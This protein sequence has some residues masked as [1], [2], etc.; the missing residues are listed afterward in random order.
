MLRAGVVCRSR[1]YKQSYLFMTVYYLGCCMLCKPKPCRSGERQSFTKQTLW[2]IFGVVAYD[3]V[4][5]YKYRLCV[6]LCHSP[7]SAFP[8]T[9]SKK[10]LFTGNCDTER[11]F[12]T[13]S[14]PLF[15]GQ[16]LSYALHDC[17][18]RFKVPFRSSK[19]EC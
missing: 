11:R 16:V 1:L 13:A 7:D 4:F 6:F 15:Q 10:L 17:W 12:C 14:L 9:K 2:I 18:T 19:C 3:G 5:C 8:R